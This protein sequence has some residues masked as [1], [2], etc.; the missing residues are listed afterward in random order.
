MGAFL[1]T[2]PPP[3]SQHDSLLLD[4]VIETPST[5]SFGTRC[6]CTLCEIQFSR[7]GHKQVECCVEALGQHSSR[8]ALWVRDCHLRWHSR[9]GEVVHA[10]CGQQS[11]ICSLQ[12]L[13]ISSQ[14]MHRVSFDVLVVSYS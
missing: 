14:E 13:L 1:G 2:F 12:W 5:L 10:G 11:W 9:T 7:P 4:L 8:D 3:P 6:I